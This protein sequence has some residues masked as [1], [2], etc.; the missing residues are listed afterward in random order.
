MNANLL[1]LHESAS[2]HFSGVPTAPSNIGY[3]R[4]IHVW[5]LGSLDNPL[6]EGSA[7]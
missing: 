4:H 2:W 1:R 7:N 3:G 5:T 6:S